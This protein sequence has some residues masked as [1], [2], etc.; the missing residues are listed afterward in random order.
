MVHLKTIKSQFKIK[1]KDFMRYCCNLF[2]YL[3]HRCFYFNVINFNTLFFSIPL[4]G[5]MTLYIRVQEKQGYVTD[6]GQ[7]FVPTSGTKYLN[8]HQKMAISKNMN[9]ETS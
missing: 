7:E 8:I 3:I 6:S 2:K 9:K 1:Y 5:K 4:V